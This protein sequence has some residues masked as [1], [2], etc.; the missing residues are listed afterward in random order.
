MMSAWEQATEYCRTIEEHKNINSIRT[1][2][3]SSTPDNIFKLSIFDPQLRVCLV[4]TWGA[5]KEY[6]ESCKGGNE[7]ISLRNAMDRFVHPSTIPNF[8]EE[9]VTEMG[10]QPFEDLFSAPASQATAR[11]VRFSD[12]GESPS[13]NA[14]YIKKGFY[15]MS[16]YMPN[17]VG[18][19]RS[20]LDGGKTGIC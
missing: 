1:F 20:N 14:A 13:D 6:H 7:S 5:Y 9:K 3:T 16:N 10:A 8:I 17:E 19:H 12:V 4:L 18:P 11:A 2:Y 15:P